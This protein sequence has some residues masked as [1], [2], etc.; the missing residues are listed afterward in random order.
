MLVL[1]G[2]RFPYMPDI[3]GDDGDFTLRLKLS[4]GLDLLASSA[5]LT[6]RA[7]KEGELLLG[8]PRLSSSRGLL[9]LIGDL[10]VDTW[11][12][13]G[14]RVELAAPSRS[15]VEEYRPQISKIIGALGFL[16][17]R[18]EQSKA[19]LS[20]EGQSKA[21]L[22]QA[23]QSK[24]ALSKAGVSTAER[25]GSQS[26]LL[27]GDEELSRLCRDSAGLSV[28][29]AVNLFSSPSV[30]EIARGVSRAM[31]SSL[32]WSEDAASQVLRAGLIDFSAT[33]ILAKKSTSRLFRERVA[34]VSE[35]LREK[36][37]AP[38]WR[39]WRGKRAPHVERG[40]AACHMLRGIFAD[41]GFGDLIR[42]FVFRARKKGEASV[43]ELRRVILQDF[44]HSLPSCLSSSFL[45]DGFLPD[46]FIKEVCVRE[47][48]RPRE[49]LYD[50]YGE[51]SNAGKYLS[52]IRLIQNGERHFHSPVVL[53]L[54]TDIGEHELTVDVD[55]RV[56]EI[57][58]MTSRPP[59]KIL[60]DPRSL[61]F[62]SNE[63]NNELDV[64]VEY[65]RI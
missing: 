8:F 23:E 60:V 21:A 22:S 51:P 55:G 42:R 38:R 16:L 34:V 63:G 52:S 61:I 64:S 58:V 31:W 49:L 48:R 9:L 6:R 39:R 29:P 27:H 56:S 24:A 45:V 13:K 36:R 25:V 65:G 1:G 3:D 32:P 18:E 7:G 19:A 5:P 54:L 47:Q 17:S 43:A 44:E 10:F 57:N 30:A 33:A 28:I 59:R 26:F 20:Q 37:P 50:A 15:L 62:E 46:F 40:F 35:V 53:K 11:H 41:K 14:A 12:V 2:E 4:A